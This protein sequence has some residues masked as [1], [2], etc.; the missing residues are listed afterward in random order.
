MRPV[1][2]DPPIA[3]AELRAVNHVYATVKYSSDGKI[4]GANHQFLRLLGYDLDE[5][6]GQDAGIFI[7]KSYE[8]SEH[9]ELWN[10]LKQGV[11]RENTGL[12]IA[13]AGKEIWLRSRY[14]PLVDDHGAVEEVVQIASDV[15]AQ[16]EQESDERGQLAAINNT[17]AVV[18][19]SLD[20]IILDANA[21]F[22]ATMGY[23]R[24][25]ILGRHHS[26][27][28]SDEDAGSQDY[29]WFWKSLAN[30]KHKSGEYCRIRKNGE[31]V[32][33]QAVYS[34][35]FDLAGRPIKVVKYASDVTAEKLRRADYEWQIKAI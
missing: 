1:Q 18:H 23:D 32:W 24:Q 29:N 14:V 17:Q 22:L 34:P 7:S 27:F 15:T 30:G 2:S 11:L 26:M 31:R 28:V 3:A 16:Q 35:I 19:F 9:A 8:R 6:V 33:L 12:W 5:I 13:K 21:I 10:S 25:E 4:L 20:G